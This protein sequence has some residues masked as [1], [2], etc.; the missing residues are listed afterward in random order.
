VS[1][2]LAETV[3]KRTMGAAEGADPTVIQFAGP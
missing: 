1:L 2:R 3:E